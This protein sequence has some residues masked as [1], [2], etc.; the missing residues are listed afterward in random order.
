MFNFV[1]YDSE[2]MM[3]MLVEKFEEGTMDPE[4]GEKISVTNANY[5]ADIRAILGTINYLGEC[6]SNMINTQTNNNLVLFCDET[7]LIYKGVERNVYRLPAEKAE[8]V[9]KFTASDSAPEAVTIPAGTKATADGVIF[10]ETVE[11]VTCAPGGNVSVTALSTEATKDANGYSVGSITIIVNTIPYIIGVTNTVISSD[12]AD[13]EDL[14]AFRQRV[15]FAPLTYSS[16]GTVNGYKYGALSVSAAIADVA[17]THDD[18]EIY[19][20]ILCQD[21]TLPSQ[22]LIDQVEAHITQDDIKA[23]TDLVTVLSAEEVE[24]TVDLSYKI[25]QRDTEKVTEIQEAVNEAIDE[26]I[27]SINVEMGLPIN[28]EML[29]K[30]AYQAGAASVTITSPSYASL[31]EYEIAKCTSKTV[32]YDG[33]LA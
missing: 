19:V 20:Y 16:V 8:T 5:D 17:V 21:G 13:I 2:S 24:Y 4:T 7:N 15:L 26:Y 32:T 23:A 10:F 27:R 1:F 14:E 28:P 9:L 29:Q 30:A 12:G 6:M 31:E 11:D 18:N 22:D 25:S 33:L 3:D